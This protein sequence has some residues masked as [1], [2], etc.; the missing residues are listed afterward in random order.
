MKST[1]AQRFSVSNSR[2]LSEATGRTMF[3]AGFMPG[4]ES[5]KKEEKKEEQ[6]IET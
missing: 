6:E 2:L 5:K 1:A 3:L 4:K